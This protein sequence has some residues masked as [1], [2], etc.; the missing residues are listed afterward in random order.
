M[1]RR[2]RKR[3]AKAHSVR[4]GQLVFAEAPALLKAIALGSCVGIAVYQEDE[5]K[6]ALAHAILP[7]DTSNAITQNPLKFVDKAVAH[8]ALRLDPK[9]SVAK[10]VGGA[11]MFRHIANTSIFNIGERNAHAAKIALKRHGIRLVGEIV[12]GHIGRT[13]S[14][15]L[16][17][18]IVVISSAGGHLATI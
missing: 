16:E 7:T 11:A 14:F 18:G 2:V 4:M 13:M 9:K 15:D 5:K 6:G 17:T 12:G 8:M 10:L 3:S 1:G